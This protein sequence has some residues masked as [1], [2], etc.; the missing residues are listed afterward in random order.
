[1]KSFAAYA[2]VLLACPML[3]PGQSGPQILT[4]RSAVDDSDQPY[5]IYLPRTFRADAK[6]PLVV[7]LHSEQ[8]THRLNLRQVLSVPSRL[9][10]MDSEDLRYFP[11]VRDE[12][13]IVVCSLARGTMG[14]QGFPERDIYDTLADVEL[15]FPN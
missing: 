9:G 3:L 13:F 12:G 6:Y 5:A 10:E 7:S 15:R 11:V 1:M 14:Y 4:F 2:A 8:S